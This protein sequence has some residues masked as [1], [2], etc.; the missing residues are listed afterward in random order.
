MNLCA[1][2]KCGSGMEFNEIT[3]DFFKY[4]TYMGLPDGAGTFTQGIPFLTEESLLHRE[5]EPPL[6]WDSQ[7]ESRETDSAVRHGSAI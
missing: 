3:Y 5:A 2:R 1:V 6:I 7:T 4:R